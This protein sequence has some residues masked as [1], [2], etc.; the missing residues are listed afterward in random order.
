MRRRRASQFFEPNSIVPLRKDAPI[1][2]FSLFRSTTLLESCLSITP[3]EALTKQQ[4]RSMCKYKDNIDKI[5]SLTQLSLLEPFPQPNPSFDCIRT[6]PFRN[7]RECVDLVLPFP[8]FEFE[9]FFVFGVSKIVD[10]GKDGAVEQ[11][12]C[13]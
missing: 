9:T 11:F 8:H 2:F 5:N 6:D 4:L 12:G 3:R 1:E 13:T 7:E 10:Q